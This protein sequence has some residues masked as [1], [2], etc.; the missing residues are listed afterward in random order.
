MAS[1]TR[2]RMGPA[3]MA[4]RGTIA[5]GTAHLSSGWGA[6]V[7]RARAVA[8]AVAGSK[9]SSIASRVS[10]GV[11]RWGTD[12]RVCV[13]IGHAFLVDPAGEPGAVVVWAGVVWVVVVAGEGHESSLWFVQ[14]AADRMSREWVNGGHSA[15]RRFR[16][17]SQVRTGAPVL[18]VTG[19]PGFRRSGPVTRALLIAA[20][21]RQ[22]GGSPGAA[23]RGR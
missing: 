1:R 8:R 20:P 19:L 9:P 10:I 6:A 21:R 15:L 17:T 7:R 13:A 22:S 2:R 14:G 4:W 12:A 23:C 3:V 18:P 11:A 5:N 16:V